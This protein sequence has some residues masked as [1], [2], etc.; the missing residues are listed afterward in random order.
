MITCKDISYSYDGLHQDLEGISY[1][2]KDGEWLGIIGPNG[3]GKSTF[4]NILCGLFKPS[5]GFVTLDEELISKMSNKEI[6]RKIAVLSQQNS[7]T[8][9]YEV[10]ETVKLGRIAHTSSLFPSWEEQDESAVNNALIMTSTDKMKESFIN[11]ISGGERQ[12]VFLAQC[13]AQDT[14]YIFLDEPSNH[15]DLMHTIKILDLLKELQTKEKKTIVTVFHDL[16]LASLYCDRLLAMKNGRP[17]IEGNTDII[18]SEQNLEDLYET[19]F[20]IMLNPKTNKKVIIYKSS[21]L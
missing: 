6:A 11:E 16:N 1:S 19:S 14:P 17:F 20:Q 7:F 8:Y 21:I 18:L 5:K 15:L 12:R 13:F 4:L 9:S 2:I 10:K 3:S